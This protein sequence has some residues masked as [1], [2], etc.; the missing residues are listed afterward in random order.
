MDFSQWN[1]NVINLSLL[2]NR[3]AAGY[4][5]ARICE[6]I[7]CGSLMSHHLPLM[8]KKYYSRMKSLQIVTDAFRR[9]QTR[10]QW[11]YTFTLLIRLDNHLNINIIMN[12]SKNNC[13]RL[14]VCLF[15]VLTNASFHFKFKRR[16]WNQPLQQ[17]NKGQFKIKNSISEMY[18][19]PE[20][21]K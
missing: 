12:I 2:M 8:L 15:M 18:R 21:A 9:A 14:L 1:L 19:L 20:S 16:R 4:N 11:E 5:R 7:N 3:K 13:T 6:Y 17:N 10:H